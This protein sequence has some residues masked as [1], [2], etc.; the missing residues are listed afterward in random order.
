MTNVEMMF[1]QMRIIREEDEARVQQIERE[2]R[3]PPLEPEDINVEDYLSRDRKMIR[4][5][6]LEESIQGQQFDSVHKSSNKK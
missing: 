6:E 1:E 5:H 2:E 3:E 4:H